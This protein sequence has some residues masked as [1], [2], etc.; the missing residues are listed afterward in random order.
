MGKAKIESPDKHFRSMS[1]INA[2]SHEN[3]TE[4]ETIE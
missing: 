1:A 3:G 2:S 4:T